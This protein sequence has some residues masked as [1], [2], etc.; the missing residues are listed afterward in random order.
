MRPQ[1]SFIGQPVRSLQ[2][3]LRIVAQTDP[4]YPNIIPDGIYGKQTVGAVAAFQQKHGLP[5]TGITDQETWDAVVR[6]Y[7]SA[8]IQIEESPPLQVVFD[9]MEVITAGQRHPNVYIAQSILHVFYLAYGGL[10]PPDITG[11]LDIPTAQALRCFQEQNNLP[12]TG[13]LDKKTWKHLALHFPIASAT[14]LENSLKNN[15]K[16]SD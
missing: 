4:G 6:I 16:A 8:Q 15:V 13:T 7:E 2:T 1:E 12:A 5:V 3:M 10:V 11:C 14:V 9:A